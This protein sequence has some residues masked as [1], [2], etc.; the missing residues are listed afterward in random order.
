MTLLAEK[1]GHRIKAT[2]APTRRVGKGGVMVSRCANPECAN[3]FRYMHEG[4]IFLVPASD[5]CK[6]VELMWLCGSCSQKMTIH[7]CGGIAKVVPVPCTLPDSIC[8]AA[9]CARVAVWR[10]LKCQRSV[11]AV[12]A[13][14]CQWDGE[15][16]CV[17]CYSPLAHL[18]SREVSVPEWQHATTGTSL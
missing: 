9:H 15:M 7:I 12:H 13:R 11:C 8:N 2:A 3:E 1:N 6:R 4:R 16:L 18:P 5:Q 17:V 10:C 14:E